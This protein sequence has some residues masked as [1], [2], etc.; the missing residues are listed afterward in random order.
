MGHRPWLAVDAGR[1]VDPVLPPNRAIAAS[2]FP[3]WSRMSA[4]DH[5]TQDTR[6]PALRRCSAAVSGRVPGRNSSA[7][8]AGMADGEAR[9]AQT[10][11][12]PFGRI[13]RR[14][15]Q[16]QR[17][18][19]RGAGQRRHRHGIGAGGGPCR[20]SETRGKPSSSGSVRRGG[21]RK[22]ASTSSRGR[23][24]QPDTSPGASPDQPLASRTSADRWPLPRGQAAAM[25]ASS[26]RRG[27]ARSAPRWRP[28]TGRQGAA[29]GEVPATGLAAAADR[30]PAPGAAPPPRADAGG[31]VRAQRCCGRQ[32]RAGQRDQRHRPM[33]AEAALHQFA[34]MA[35]HA[36][37]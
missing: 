8:R 9:R 15:A 20:R 32:H 14:A 33:E 24:G 23:G 28:S 36:E 35:R 1:Q 13:T 4:S 37:T 5:V 34:H 29:Q 2:R 16:R 3:P 7:R 18:V 22:P 27:P 26:P 17:P 19:G 21:P 30:L 11:P 12:Q 10:L 6:N 25:R 31:R